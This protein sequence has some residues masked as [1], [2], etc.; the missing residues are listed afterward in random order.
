MV[1]TVS[2]IRAKTM[3]TVKNKF[4]PRPKK[5]IEDIGTIK[6]YAIAMKHRY[7]INGIS[8]GGCVTRV[9]KTLEEHP[10]IE[11]VEI[12]LQPVGATIVKMNKKLTVEELQGQLNELDGYTIAEIN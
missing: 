8:C 4:P 1:V 6:N 3:I 5:N 10:N 11:N 7:Q 2:Q 9:K 12:F